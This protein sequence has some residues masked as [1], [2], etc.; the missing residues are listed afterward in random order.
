MH[1][2]KGA[3]PRAQEYYDFF[4]LPIVW[5][6]SYLAS[7]CRR[8]TYCTV[9]GS[10]RVLGSNPVFFLPEKYAIHSSIFSH[11]SDQFVNYQIK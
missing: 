8:Y 9:P 2:T 6:D 4:A 5:F 11:L 1:S 10:N 7:V 3:S